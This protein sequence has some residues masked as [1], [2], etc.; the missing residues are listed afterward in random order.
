MVRQ[1][2]GK[3]NVR[4]LIAWKS[5]VALALI[6]GVLGGSSRLIRHASN[7][8]L[9]RDAQKLSS[10]L[11]EFSSSRAQR[12]E[13]KPDERFDE[14]RRRVIREDTE[15]QSLYAKLYYTR[16]G[17]VR[18]QFAKRNLSDKALDE[19]YQKP[20]HPLAIREV[21]KRLSSMASRLRSHQ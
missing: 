16:V 8:R 3:L 10:E 5:V 13:R 17:S 11:V 21:G 7:K 2:N 15:T 4:A 12:T 6:C 19:F 1:G 20:V 9:A 14:Y 18:D